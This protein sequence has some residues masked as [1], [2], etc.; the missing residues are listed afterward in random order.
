MGV[1]FKGYLTQ[2]KR[3]PGRLLQ[4]CFNNLNNLSGKL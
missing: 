1:L 3:T 2:V 4:K